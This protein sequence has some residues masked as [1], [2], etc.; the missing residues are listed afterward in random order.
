MP[1]TQYVN[2]ETLYM[3]I[4][5]P[6][7]DSKKNRMLADLINNAGTLLTGWLQHAVE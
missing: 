3:N 6:G 4:Q 5:K 7:S 1:P 2:D